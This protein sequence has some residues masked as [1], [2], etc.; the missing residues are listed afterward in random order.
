MYCEGD[1]G[2]MEGFARIVSQ[3]YC[4]PCCHPV[5]SRRDIFFWRRKDVSARRCDMTACFGGSLYCY[6]G[7]LRTLLSSRSASRRDICLAVQ[8]GKMS[9]RGA[10]T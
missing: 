5:A 10:A 8:E 7:V 3:E 9:P 4:A 6:S 1:I 2:Q